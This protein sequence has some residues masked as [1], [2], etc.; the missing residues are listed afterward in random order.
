MKQLKLKLSNQAMVAL[1]AGLS[2]AFAVL[3]PLD[4]VVYN[5]DTDKLE[6]VP[7]N[8]G[9]RFLVVLLLCIPV[10]LHVYTI[11]CMVV[12]QCVIWSWIV[13]VLYALW[14]AL[15]LFVAFAH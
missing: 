12:G 15:F 2:L 9:H 13:A 14:I 5:E 10:A 11:N 6:L 3:L 7:Y 8:F 1:V 4:M